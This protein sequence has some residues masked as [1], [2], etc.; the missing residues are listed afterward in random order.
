MSPD[1]LAQKLGNCPLFEHLELSKITIILG[2][3][4]FPVSTYPKG[5]YLYLRGDRYRE[6]SIIASGTLKAEMSDSRGHVLTVERLSA[7]QMIASAFL[8]SP[9]NFLPLDVVAETDVTIMRISK[10]QLFTLCSEDN[11]MFQALLADVGMRTTFLSQKLY[12]TKFLTLKNKLAMFL[13]DEYSRTGLS[14]FIIPKSKQ[15]LADLFGVARTSVSRVCTK[16]AEHGLIE[17]QG[18]QFRILDE[19]ALKAA[20]MH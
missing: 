16:F 2:R 9:E 5:K 1:T 11:N 3:H 6:L 10:H 8:F 20:S 19:N 14:E 12:M 4:C 13:L 17:F 7:C 15:Q 18:R